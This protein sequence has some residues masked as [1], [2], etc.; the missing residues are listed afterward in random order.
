MP[1][2]RILI[3]HNRYRI[4]GG[5]DTVVDTEARLLRDGGCEVEVHFES[6]DGPFSILDGVRLISCSSAAGSLKAKIASF[7]PEV[8]HFHNIYYR[9]GPQAYWW[10]HDA[11]IPVVQ[12]LHNF[13]HG[14]ANARHNRDGKPCELCISTHLGR[15]HG[16]AR[17]CF[18]KSVMKTLV[19]D[20][21]LQ[22]HRAQGSFRR[23]VAM[24]ICLS[25]FARA[26]HLRA[27]IP[28]ERLVVKGN[29]VHPDPGRAEGAGEYCLFA[30]RLEQDKGIRVLL[31]AAAGLPPSVPLWIAGEGSEENEVRQAAARHPNIRFL[32][33]V[34]RS[35][36]LALLKSARL[37]LFPTMAYENFPMSIAEASAV[38]V[39]VVTSGIGAAAEIVRHGITG[40]HFETGSPSALA[41]TIRDVWDDLARLQSM[42]SAARALYETKYSTGAAFLDLQAVYDRALARGPLR[43]AAREPLPAA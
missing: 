4:P 33:K 42:G 8:V 11:G 21:A 16:V 26:L 2:Q 3:V 19:L 36:V 25:E 23:A 7:R 30:G 29:C 27:G 31:D 24:F 22:V 38:G 43:S 6:N 5:E 28:A 1:A 34:D 13:R 18:Q 39:P 14:C 15:L 20:T 10:C 37:L 40:L 35:R 12:T 32:G 17:G 41:A 9:M